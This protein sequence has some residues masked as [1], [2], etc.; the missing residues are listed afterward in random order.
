MQ[1][2]ILIAKD[3]NILDDDVELMNEL[4]GS[5]YLCQ[6]SRHKESRKLCSG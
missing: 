1:Y 4:G 3:Q 2:K 5:L 6:Q